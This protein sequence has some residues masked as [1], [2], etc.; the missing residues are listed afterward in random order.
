MRPAPGRRA[1]PIPATRRYWRHNTPH[2]FEHR[3]S[4]D[5]HIGAGGDR[6]LRGFGRDAAI[7]FQRDVAA[8]L[9]ISFAAAS[10]FFN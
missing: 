8:G 5:K 1:I 4:R 10:I 9:A 6:L 7:D 2:P 3:R